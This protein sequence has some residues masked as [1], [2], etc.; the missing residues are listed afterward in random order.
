MT[1]VKDNATN[2]QGARRTVITETSP[3]HGGVEI[4]L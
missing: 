2:I 4:K 3:E 1:V